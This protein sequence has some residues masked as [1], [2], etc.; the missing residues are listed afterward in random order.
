MCQHTQDAKDERPNR[1]EPFPWHL[2]AFDAHC[3]P[4]DTMASIAKIKQMRT[5]LLTIMATRA[6]DQ[7]LVADV[8][9]DLG[10][11]DR[12]CSEG[13]DGVVP[14][15]GWHPW[16]SHQIYD[17]SLSEPTF[18]P[19]DDDEEDSKRK[20]YE[21]VL[22][23]LPKDP[24]FISSLPNPT[25]LSLFIS[26]ARRFL[27]SHPH[28]LVGEIGLDKAFRLPRQWSPIN[29]AARDVGLTPGGREG[30]LLSPHRVKAQHQQ[31]ILDAQLRLAGEL[32]RPVS[33]HAVQAHGVLFDTASKT[34]KG[35]EKEHISR[36]K[37][38]L[39]AP[40]AESD[41]D[42]NEDQEFRNR[43]FPPRICLHSFSGSVEVLRQ[44]LKPTI[45]SAI[46]FSFSVVINMSTEAGRAKVV[47]VIRE[48][49][50]DR[51]LVESDLHAAGEDMDD[52]L[53]DIYRMVCEI[54]GWAL[55][56]GVERI[57]KNFR[58]F[59]FGR[60]KM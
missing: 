53:E 52:M 25:P 33:V 31:T 14:A 42:D 29:K 58:E 57:G 17:D 6:Q 5:R 43:P 26:S 24:E 12:E 37:R 45:P 36:K 60:M 34:W 30:R 23:P 46:F 40:G 39:A 3:H 13:N 9:T 54:K 56:E 55:K 41:S 28:A 48:V 18:K 49:P 38:K 35:Y 19:V 50:D 11:A 47:D 32:C 4:T 7:Q 20:H 2:G 59:I 51:L 8:A 15:F 16:F 27:N 21:A 1:S 44:W 22:Q 10:I